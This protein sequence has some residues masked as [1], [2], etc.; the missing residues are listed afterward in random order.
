VAS[1]TQIAWAAGILEGEGCFTLVRNTKA[2]GGRSAKV[3]L[4]MNDL[5][6]IEKVQSVFEGK[7]KVYRR[8]PKG[9][10]KESWSWQVYRAAD[11]KE[12]TLSVLPWLCKRRTEKAHQILNW[13]DNGV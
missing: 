9:S 5:D 11:V 10:S 3:V 7:G 12:I 1:E 2:K 8:P 4:Q 6:V 13:I